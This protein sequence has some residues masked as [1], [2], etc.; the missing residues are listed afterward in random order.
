MLPCVNAVLRSRNLQ[1]SNRCYKFPTEF[2][3]TAANFQQWTSW[4]IN[5]LIL[6][7]NFHQ[8]C[9]YQPQIFLDKSILTTRK[10]PTIFRQ[11]KIL[12]EQ[13]LLCPL[14]A[15]TPLRDT[16]ARCETNVSRQYPRC[17][18]FALRGWQLMRIECDG[19]Q[20]RSSVGINVI[21]KSSDVIESCSHVPVDVSNYLTARMSI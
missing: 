7:Q 8:K 19:Q 5:I 18:E 1:F 10:F 16:A 12:G 6:L 11:L 2:R 13:M 21:I 20:S 4:V 15:K 14:A 3:Q 9:E 17:M